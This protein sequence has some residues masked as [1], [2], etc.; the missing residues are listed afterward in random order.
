[1]EGYEKEKDTFGNLVR[2]LYNDKGLLDKPEHGIYRINQKGIHK[3]KYREGTLAK[4]QTDE[5]GEIIR[6]LEDFFAERKN[7]I[8]NHFYDSQPFPVKFSKLEKQSYELIEWFEDKPDVFL[9]AVEKALNNAVPGI[10][11]YIPHQIEVDVDYW[12][13]TVFE[14]RES[15]L[16]NNPVTLEATIESATKPHPEIAAATFECDECGLQKEKEQNS[17]E[18]QAPYK[19]ECGSKKFDTIEKVMTDT[20]IV[21]LE[22]DPESR[23]GSEQPSSLSVRL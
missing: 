12:K 11:D 1:E 21:T 16:I 18:L 4:T 20:Q 8:K 9:D 13:N 19:C 17:T 3:V 10:D 2:K 23:E 5:Y 6:Q 22:E 14:S 7:R 15:S